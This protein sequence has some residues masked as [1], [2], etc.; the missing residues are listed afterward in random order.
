MT[1][2]NVSRGGRCPRL[3][4]PP[5]LVLYQD[6]LQLHADQICHH[7]C[8]PNRM[9]LCWNTG[10]SNIWIGCGL[11]SRLESKKV[12][13]K[14]VWIQWYI[15]VDEL[16]RSFPQC[17]YIHGVSSQTGWCSTPENTAKLRIF[18]NPTV[19]SNAD[20]NESQYLINRHLDRNHE[21]GK[22]LEHLIVLQPIIGGRRSVCPMIR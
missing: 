7:F 13:T 21:L 12:T 10:S 3:T 17:A 18:F 14:A 9:T 2:L 1:E 8:C 16:I 5:R 22:P 4:A 6:W 11:S 19:S 15:K 20:D